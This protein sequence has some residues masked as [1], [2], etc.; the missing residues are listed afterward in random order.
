VA[1]ERKVEWEKYGW[2]AGQEHTNTFAS[3]MRDLPGQPQTLPRADKYSRLADARIDRKPYP[4][5]GW[6]FFKTDASTRHYLFAVG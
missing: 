4:I 5:F 2:L 3:R 6:I 1:A